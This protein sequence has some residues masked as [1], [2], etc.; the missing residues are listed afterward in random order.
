LQAC[1][2]IN[3][4]YQVGAAIWATVSQAMQEFIDH[5]SDAKMLA[6]QKMMS[7][8]VRASTNIYISAYDFVPLYGYVY[9]TA[10]SY[11]SASVFAY[12]ALTSASAV[13]AEGAAEA[14]EAAKQSVEKFLT[15]STAKG[16]WN[17][18][19]KVQDNMDL[20]VVATRKTTEFAH[21]VAAFKATQETLTGISVTEGE[22]SSG[23]T[24]IKALPDRFY[25]IAIE[26]REENTSSEEQVNISN[27]IE[28]LKRERDLIDR[29][30]PTLGQINKIIALIRNNRHLSK[31]AYAD[32]VQGVDGAE[33]LSVQELLDASSTDATKQFAAEVEYQVVGRPRDRLRRAELEQPEGRAERER[34]SQFGKKSNDVGSK[35][36]QSMQDCIDHPS[37]ARM[38]AAQEA[39]FTYVYPAVSAAT[40]AYTSLV[41]CSPFCSNKPLAYISTFASAFASASAYASIAASTS[42]SV[43][44]AEEA[45]EAAEQIAVASA[46]VAT[47][48]KYTET[49]Q[50]DINWFVS[51]T[52]KAA[53]FARAAAILRAVIN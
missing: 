15:A 8:Y 23:I 45:A 12:A 41:T 2:S 32:E 20:F 36:L 18:F 38:L 14:A 43:T 30:K 1:S 3:S 34:A 39:I 37:V 46:A 33:K 53:E 50:E 9:A 16:W 6:V 5:P 51:A 19:Y 29:S 31:L 35:M 47:S 17:T 52:R 13:E 49:M 26:N 21:A 40:S 48:V 28:H 25:G 42:T 10:A 7:S 4:N 11:A 22:N 24:G 27:W 44:E